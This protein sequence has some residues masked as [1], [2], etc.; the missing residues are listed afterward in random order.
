MEQAVRDNSVKICAWIVYGLQFAAI[1]TCGLTALVGFIINLVKR[2]D[3]KAAGNVYD[4]HFRWQIRT[5]LWALFWYIV[6][7]ILCLIL[8]GFVMLAI[9]F[10]WNI[11]RIIKGA[12]RL[13]EDREA[14]S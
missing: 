12:L 2:D 5:F 7:W 13:S 11:Y 14:Y 4:S 10:L 8:I 3:A 1:F 9:T 6:S